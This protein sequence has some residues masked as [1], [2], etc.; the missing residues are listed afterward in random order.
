MPALSYENVEGVLEH[1][2]SGYR[3]KRDTPSGG[4]R[5]EEQRDRSRALLRGT[6]VRA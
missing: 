6:E 4:A 5:H 1:D 2:D 3:G